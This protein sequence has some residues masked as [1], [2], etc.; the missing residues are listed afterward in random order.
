MSKSPNSQ[1][2]ADDGLRLGNL[3]KKWQ[4]AKMT[5]KTCGYTKELPK[6][7]TNL[8]SDMKLYYQM[9]KSPDCSMWTE[10][11]G[12][13]TGSQSGI[14]KREISQPHSHQDQESPRWYKRVEK[15]INTTH[16]TTKRWILKRYIF[17]TPIQKLSIHL[18]QCKYWKMIFC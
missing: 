5:H 2:S 6:E 18:S 14:L 17:L 11:F 1:D 10:R 3:C 4:T 15:T 7:S 12:T 16:L 8:G 9:G 13:K